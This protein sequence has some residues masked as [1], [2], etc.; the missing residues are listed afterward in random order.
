[1]SSKWF[2]SYRPSESSNNLTFFGAEE[3]VYADPVRKIQEQLYDQ[4]IT[5][6]EGFYQTL[7]TALSQVEQTVVSKAPAET[8]AQDVEESKNS[9]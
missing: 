8:T 4:L 6:R 7:V 2:N 5:I 9:S 1:M 3:T